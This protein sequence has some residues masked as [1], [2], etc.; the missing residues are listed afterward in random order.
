MIRIPLAVLRTGLG[1][2]TVGLTTIVLGSYMIVFARFW[3]ESPQIP[4]AIRLWG[5]IFLFSTRARVRVVGADRVD[6]NGSYVFTGN[7][8]SNL[9]I[10][11]ILGRLPVSVRFLAK[12]ELF[13]VPV[14]GGA[15]RAIKMV[16]TDRG[17]G[18]AAHRAINEQ[19]AGVVAS[20]LSLMIFPE[21]TRSR[22]AEMMPFKKGAFRIAVDN[23]M[24]VVPLTILGAHAAWRPGS[25][26]IFGG[27][28]TLIIHDP[29]PTDG[30]DNGQL[31]RLRDDVRAI[32]KDTYEEMRV[33]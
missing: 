7:H 12:K 11:A 24:P 28:I 4:K 2:F 10:P 25:K 26:L 6:S 8:T 1:M 31:N 16:E 33:R 5:R 29:I 30:L 14:L 17:A 19:V 22:D 27:R 32:V 20:G 3:P 23:A 18:T 15:M 9:D 21:G 13:R